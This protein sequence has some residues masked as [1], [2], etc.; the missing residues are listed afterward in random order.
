MRCI[1]YVNCTLSG[2]AQEERSAEDVGCFECNKAESR[3]Q[4]QRLGSP[5]GTPLNLAHTN[6]RMKVCKERV[7]SRAIKRQKL[8]SGLVNSRIV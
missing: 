7:L 4:K 8:P 2:P 5:Q 3:C 1:A 6:R